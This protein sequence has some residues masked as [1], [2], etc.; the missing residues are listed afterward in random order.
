[1]CKNGWVGRLSKCFKH[2]FWL[3]TSLDLKKQQHNKCFLKSALPPRLSLVFIRR[4][5]TAV[6]RLPALDAKSRRWISDV[7]ARSTHMLLVRAAIFSPVCD[8]PLHSPYVKKLHS[9]S[10]P[11]SGNNPPGVLDV[12]HMKMSGEG[13]WVHY[14]LRRGPDLGIKCAST[15]A[16]FYHLL[17]KRLCWKLCS[18]VNTRASD[19]CDPCS[20][21]F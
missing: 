9:L 12:T 6:T 17:W 18:A 13:L 20:V 7:S 14:G 21:Y 3:E 1:M 8:H 11:P 4:N 10:P 16:F 2:S 19:I 15:P 5:K